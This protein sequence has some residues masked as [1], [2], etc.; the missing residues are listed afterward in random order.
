VY[1]K[2]AVQTAKHAKYAKGKGVQWTRTFTHCE[3]LSSLAIR[4]AFAWFPYFAVPSAFY[5]IVSEQWGAHAPRVSCLAPSPNSSD[6]QMM[7]WRESCGFPSAGAP[8][9]A[10]RAAALPIM[11]A[12][13]NTAQPARNQS[14]F[15]H[16]LHSAAKPQPK[17]RG[18]VT[19]VTRRSFA[20]H[21]AF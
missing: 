16:G 10:A 19:S 4:S 14:S 18:S 12:R 15:N 20:G 8:A 1:L 13:M 2:P 7:P 11:N 3:N 9:G 5:R 21:P 6:V 17:E